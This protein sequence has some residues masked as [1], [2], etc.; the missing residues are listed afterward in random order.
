RT[1]RAT[2]VC[3]N[4]TDQSQTI[5]V[6]DQTWAV[7]GT[8]PGPANVECASAVPSADISLV[9]ASDACGGVVTISH[10]G[11]VISAQTCANRYTITRTYRATDVCGNF[12]DQSQ[13]ITVND[14]TGPVIGT[15]PGPANVEC[16]S[17]VPSADISL[18]SA[19][20]ACGG[21]VTISH[22]GDVIS[23]QTCA[24]R[25]TITRTYRATDVCGNF[26]DQSQTIT[27]NDQTGPVIGTFPGPANVEC[28]SAVPSAD[29]SLVSASDACG[30]VVTISH[31]GDVISAQTCANRY[32]ITRTYRATDVCG[33]FTDQ[34]QTITVNDQTGP[35]IGTFPGP[36]N[37]ECASAVPSADISLVSASDACGG[38]VTISHVGDVISAQT[39]ANR[40]TITRTYRATDV[41]GNFTDQSQ[42]ITVNDQTGPVI[43]TF[44]GPANVEC[45][46]A[47][48]SADIS[49]VSASDA[50]GGVVTISHVGD[51]ISAQTCANRY[52]ITRTY[53]ATDVCGNFT[54]QSQTITVNDQTGPVIGTFPGPANVEC[55]SAV[56]SADISLV[57]ASDACGGV[58]TI[59]HV[60]DVISAQTC[61][62]RYTITRT[63]RATDVCGNF[64][65]QSQTITVNDQTG[66]VIGT[67]PG[68]A[69]VECASAVPSADISLVSASDACGG[70]VTISHV[71][72]VISAQTCANRY[73]ITRTYRATDVCG[74]FTDQ[75]QTITVNDQTGPVIG[76]FPGPAN[77]ECA[78]AVPSAD[79]SLVSASDACGG[80]VTISH[81]GDVI[82]A[83]TC[84]NR[85]TITR[86]YRATDVC[87]NFTDQSQTITVNDQTGP[88]IGTFPG[89]A[90][91]ECASAVPSA[92][93]S[94]VS[95]SDACG[96]VVTISHVGDVISA[97]TCANRYTITRTYRAT[98]VCGNF[99]DQSQTITVND[100]TGPV[101]GT[102]PGPANVECAS[103]VP[104]AD[105]SLVSASDA[106]GGVVTISHVGDVIS[107]QTCANRYTITRTYRA[108]DVCGN[109]T[110][111]SQTITVNDQTGPVIGTF[112]GPA[113]V[114]CAS[115][116]PSADISLVSASDACGGVVTIS[117]VGDVISAQTC[118]N[119]YTITRT[120]RATD[121]C[122]NFA[123]CTQIITV[124]DQTAPALTCPGPVTVSGASAVPAPNTASVTGVSDNCA[125]VV[126]ITHQGDVISAQ[127]CANRYTIT[128]TYRA[129]DVC[130]NFAE[131][132]QIITVNDQTPPTL[133]CPVPITVSCAS[134]V[135]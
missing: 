132:T 86:T 15:F 73:T 98:D 29:I 30:G 43:G 6:N 127:T 20:D 22:V 33:N 101:I 84:A 92:D 129:T 75:S 128:R 102:F 28:A 13:T 25:Y 135:P 24:N 121:V 41:C 21:V 9:S 117:H 81:V 27:V 119:R 32:T 72:D 69:N 3:G 77:V 110:D 34:S 11:D 14:Q 49:L 39:C 126:T 70:V 54:D 123:E 56:P 80:V 7:I 58:V 47:V 37:V 88:V 46:S 108:T 38:V 122:G 48:P 120:Y 62:N 105:I 82:S 68:P 109:F 95:A 100:Q 5:T 133:T 125:G 60:G 42:T 26:T 1:Y 124:N 79:I 18:V 130:G 4:F 52:T 50:C 134:A 65:D 57:S 51:V 66:P 17:A 23:A 90:N 12:T 114:E 53:R 8:F 93:I 67:F 94:L 31:V 44:P 97:Q 91:V 36:A 19:S 104:S 131:C 115:A 111:Q 83:Q 118:A 78:S 96:G 106:C 64:T 2:D 40:Y 89:P 71:G 61:A 55:A 74:N 59:S 45:A 103:A 85:Y 35:V 63:Y 76:T 10:V 112:P 16:A 116:V 87:G 107:A 99:T 113:N